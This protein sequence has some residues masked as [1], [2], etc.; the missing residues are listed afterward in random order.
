M[1]ERRAKVKFYREWKVCLLF[2]L[3]NTGITVLVLSADARRKQIEVSMLSFV[4]IQVRN[5]CTHR[6]KL[7]R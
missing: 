7:N 3:W 1:L 6:L 5:M 2:I 4:M